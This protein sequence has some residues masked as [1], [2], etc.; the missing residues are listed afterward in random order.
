MAWGSCHQAAST[1][2]QLCILI[3]TVAAPPLPQNEQLPSSCLSHSTLSVFPSLGK[4]PPSSLPKLC[5]DIFFLIC[6]T[7]NTLCGFF[8]PIHGAICLSESMSSPDDY[9]SLWLTP[10]LTYCGTQGGSY[11]CLWKGL[12]LL[13]LIDRQSLLTPWC[14]KWVSRWTVSPLCPEVRLGHTWW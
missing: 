12:M 5:F 14:Q 1:G 9:V 8:G 2:P 3:C 7:Q 4:M 10:G 6:V 11:Q 13:F